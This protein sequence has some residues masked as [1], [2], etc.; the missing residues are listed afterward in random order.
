MQQAEFFELGKLARIHYMVSRRPDGWVLSRLG[1]RPGFTSSSDYDS[2]PLRTSRGK[3]RTFR[4]LE[5]VAA[6]C[7]SNNVGVIQVVL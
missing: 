5:T 3:I 1:Y 4:S 6:V 7:R 2:G